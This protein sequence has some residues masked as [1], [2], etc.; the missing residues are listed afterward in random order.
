MDVVEGGHILSS[1]IRLILKLFG[2]GR[3]SSAVIRG[4]KIEVV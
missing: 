4:T 2:F 1:W 3:E